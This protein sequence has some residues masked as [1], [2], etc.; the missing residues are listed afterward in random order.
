[1]STSFKE[2]QQIGEAGFISLYEKRGLF[3]STSYLST[4][5][6][7][8]F[9]IINPTHL[10]RMEVKLTGLLVPSLPPEPFLKVGVVLATPQPSDTG[11]LQL[12][13]HHGGPSELLGERHLILVTY[14]YLVYQFVLKLP[15]W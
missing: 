8:L 15:L 1:M 3:P 4:R 11:H 9:S 5:Q 7:I 6:L 13:F 2:I 12:Q 14:W 10:L